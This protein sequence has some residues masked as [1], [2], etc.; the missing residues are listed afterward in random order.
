MY[1]VQASEPE[2][3]GDPNIDFLLGEGKII[4]GEISGDLSGNL[5]VVTTGAAEPGYGPLLYDTTAY[6]LNQRGVALTHSPNQS[7]D[8]KRVWLRNS[9]PVSWRD[10]R[11]WVGPTGGVGGPRIWNAPT[12]SEYYERYGLLPEDLIRPKAKVKVLRK[13][14]RM[15]TASYWGFPTEKDLQRIRLTAW[16]RVIPAWRLRTGHRKPQHLTHYALLQVHKG[17]SLFW[18]STRKSFG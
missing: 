13:I 3:G 9:T 4:V 2:P 18:G 14:G 7:E 5:F 11:I 16:G 17:N 12:Q 1:F 6:L 10:P 15:F 8:A